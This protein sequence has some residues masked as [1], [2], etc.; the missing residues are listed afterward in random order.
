MQLDYVTE[1]SL[2][3]LLLD[4]TL[5]VSPLGPMADTP[6]VNSSAPDGRH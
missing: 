1:K 4:R 3:R 6:W 2:L 5:A